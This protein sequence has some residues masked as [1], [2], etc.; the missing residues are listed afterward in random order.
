[1]IDDPSFS[2]ETIM[3]RLRQEDSLMRC[4]AE[5]NS[6]T[7]ST[8]FAA[9]GRGKPWP[10]CTDCKKLGHLVDFCIRP[11]GKMAGRSIKEARTA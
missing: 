3:R 1:M 4:R 2:S 8:A 10:V 9:H 11:G 7:P 6:Q 5:Q